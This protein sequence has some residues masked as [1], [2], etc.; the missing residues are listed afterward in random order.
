[1]F[2]KQCVDALFTHRRSERTPEQIAADNEHAINRLVRTT[3]YLLANRRLGDGIFIDHA[4]GIDL[5]E[6]IA[7][8]RAEIERLRAIEAAARAAHDAERAW[9]EN[10]GMN[11]GLAGAMCDA[12]A[13]LR[14]VLEKGGAK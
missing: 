7:A 3:E 6:A 9:R 10:G 12:Q 8:M 5:R 11:P 1:M 4:Q 2:C 14:N 13:V